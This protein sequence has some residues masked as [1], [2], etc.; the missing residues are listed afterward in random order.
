MK[1]TLNIPDD[2]LKETVQISK[3]RAKTEAVIEGLRELIRQRRIERV[4]SSVG[5]MEF[6]DTWDTARHGR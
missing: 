5:K 2:L 1:T 4:L 6:S 3:S